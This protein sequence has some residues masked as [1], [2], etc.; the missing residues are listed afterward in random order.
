MLQ[1][2]AAHL[3]GEYAALWQ[4]NPGL[5]QLL[6]HLGIHV[7]RQF[8]KGVLVTCIQRTLHAQLSTYGRGS[9]QID[10]RS[11]LH[12]A[13]LD[14]W[15]PDPESRAVGF[16]RLQQRASPHLFWL[17]AD[18]APWLYTAEE[19]RQILAFLRGFDAGNGLPTIPV[20]RSRTVW[21][22]AAGS[23]GPHLHIQYHGPLRPLPAARH[24]RG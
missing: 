5:A 16:A 9:K 23:R 15:L 22:H 7:R 21:L 17:A 3:A 1:F 13:D 11:A 20:A 24:R 12:R 18:I 10:P 14:G 2:S 19:T 6:G 8:R 4:H